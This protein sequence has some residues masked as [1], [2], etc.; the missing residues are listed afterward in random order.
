MSLFGSPDDATW[1]DAV[2]RCQKCGKPATGLLMGSR[3]QRLGAYCE[4]HAIERI[5]AAKD[6]PASAATAFGLRR[7]PR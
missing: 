1:F 6:G 4:P 5:E 2:G 3:N 7:P